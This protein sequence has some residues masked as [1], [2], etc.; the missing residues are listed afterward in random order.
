MTTDLAHRERAGAIAKDTPSNRWA[1]AG[2]LKPYAG[3][4]V[5]EAPRVDALATISAGYKNRDGFPVVSRDGTIYIRD[6]AR[7]P[8]L[9]AELERRGNK[10]LTIALVSDR[11]EDVIQQRFTAYSKTRLEAH[12]DADQITVI[13]LKDTGRKDRQGNAVMVGERETVRR[14]ANAPRYGQL[15]ASMKV[16]TSLYFALATWEG[17]QPR[18][19]FPDGLGL[20]RLAFTSLNSAEAIKA[21]LA[22]IAGL[23]GDRVAGVPLELSI[24]YRDHAGP[25]GVRRNVPIWSL[26]LHPPQTIKLD[27]ARVASILQSGIDQARALAIAAP[28]PETIDLA[29]YEGPD[30]DMDD[31]RVID[32]EVMPPSRRDMKR[33]SGGGPITNPGRARAEFFMAVGRKS[34]LYHEDGRA[35]FVQAFTNGRTDSLATFIET[36]TLHEWADFMD[37]V[38]DWTRQ[39][40]ES[41]Q[42]QPAAASPTPERS[43]RSYEDLFVDDEMPHN[44]APKPPA[45]TTTTTPADLTD[46]EIDTRFAQST[47]RVLGRKPA[48]RTGPTKTE[49]IVELRKVVAEVKDAG[50]SADLATDDAD[51]LDL[52][53]DVLAEMIG[54]LRT[55]LEGLRS[56]AL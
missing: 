40:A 52:G 15:A 48:E 30:V 18:L 25:D 6:A 11:V 29:V 46:D 14:E 10:A 43:G 8:G 28:S 44:E 3:G 5:S 39:E 20:Y 56:G 24:V 19:I 49:L 42:D 50:G 51:L 7:A 21:Q 37:A 32:G 54:S 9:V 41:R 33:L 1:S 45:A 2:L 22:H 13:H 36:T 27:P 16:Q 17:E 23:T 31:A 53:E 26:V 4:L 34:A 38:S 55:G 47:E 35:P 12:G